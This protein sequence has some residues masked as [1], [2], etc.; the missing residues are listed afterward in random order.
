MTWVGVGS[1]SRR[2]LRSASELKAE[3]DNSVEAG[4]TCIAR[5]FG[6]IDQPKTAGIQLLRLMFLDVFDKI[7]L[8]SRRRKSEVWPWEWQQTSKG[9][10]GPIS[11]YLGN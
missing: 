6:G 5:L 9:Q 10:R 7:T 2:G 3:E 4:G 11:T 1:S 8:L